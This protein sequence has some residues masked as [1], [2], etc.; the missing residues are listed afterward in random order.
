MT[1]NDPY[2]GNLQIGNKLDWKHKKRLESFVLDWKQKKDIE[3]T[4]E[5]IYVISGQLRRF[6]SEI[7]KLVFA[8]IIAVI[9]HFL[10]K[11]KFEHDKRS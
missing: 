8:T 1:S 10:K 6:Q 2:D 4:I 9:G 5:T 7:E 11:L 3:N